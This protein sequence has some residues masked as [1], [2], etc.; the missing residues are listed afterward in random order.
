MRPPWN[1]NHAIL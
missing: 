1:W